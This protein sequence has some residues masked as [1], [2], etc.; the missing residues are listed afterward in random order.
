MPVTLDNGIVATL[1]F[2]P[3]ALSTSNAAATWNDISTRLRSVSFGYGKSAEL[4][5]ASAGSGNSTAHGQSTRPWRWP[6]AVQGAVSSPS[7]DTDYSTTSL[8]PA[9]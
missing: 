4:D 2:S 6:L 3:T 1:E 7:R 8:S 9:I 5:P